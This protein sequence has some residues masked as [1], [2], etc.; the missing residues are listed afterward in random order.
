MHNPALGV[1]SERVVAMCIKI[2]L[3]LDMM[4]KQERINILY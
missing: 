3:S 2:R 4:Q 1:E